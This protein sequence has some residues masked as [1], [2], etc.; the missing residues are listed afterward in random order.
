MLGIV[1]K[2]WWF[3]VAYFAVAFWA[4]WSLQSQDGTDRGLV[5]MMGSMIV[6]FPLAAMGLCELYEERLKGYAFLH[7]LPITPGEIVA[8]K[9]MMVVGSVL[10][11]LG[12]CLF[13]LH[14]EP[15]SADFMTIGRAYLILCALAGVLLPVASYVFIYRFGFTGIFRVAIF[16]MPIILMIGPGL[17]LILFRNNINRLDPAGVAALASPLN[18]AGVCIIGLVLSALLAHLAV[19]MKTARQI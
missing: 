8:A 1:K 18:V 3:Y 14:G 6:M 9:L 15:V 19:R 5:I 17:L 11:W 16:A 13:L 10:L 7:T 12:Y 2:D 4:P